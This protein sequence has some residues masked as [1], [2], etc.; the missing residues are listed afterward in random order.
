[1]P[2]ASL[3]T[4]S[5]AFIFLCLFRDAAFGGPHHD[6]V[7]GLLA[8]GAN[9]GRYARM[10]AEGSPPVHAVVKASEFHKFTKTLRPV[11][12]RDVRQDVMH[13]DKHP[14]LRSG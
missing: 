9:E 13:G 6:E 12:F 2:S 8:A 7:I 10:L 5:L 14:R 3:A 11:A 1:M 4:L